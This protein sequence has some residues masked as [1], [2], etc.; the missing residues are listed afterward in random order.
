M[1]KIICIFTCLLLFIYCYL[2]IHLFTYLFIINLFICFPGTPQINIL[3][4]KVS[5]LKKRLEKMKL[6]SLKTPKELLTRSSDYLDP[7]LLRFFKWQILHSVEN[8]SERKYGIQEKSFA[9]ALYY[10]SPKAYT[11]LSSLFYLPPVQTLQSSLKTH[12]A[13]AGWSKHS[14]IVLKSRADSLPKEEILCGI[15]FGSM[16]IKEGLHFD[17]VTE[18]VK[19]SEGLGHNGTSLDQANRVLVFMVR[20]LVEKWKLVLGCF[21]HAGEVSTSNLKELYKESVRRVQST[22]HRVIFTVCDQKEKAHCS[23]FQALG[24][25]REDPSLEVEG[26][27]IHFFYD[28]PYLLRNL[29]NTLLSYDMNVKGA[30]VSWDHIKQ[31]IEVDERQKIRL[32]PRLTSTHVCGDDSSLIDET[33]ASQVMSRSVAAGIY[34]HCVM[35]MLPKDAVHTAEFIQQVDKL[36][37]LLHNSHTLQVC[38][39]T[40]GGNSKSSHQ[41]VISEATAYLASLEV[42][43]PP[44]AW[45]Q[46]VEGWLI[47][48]ASLQAVCQELNIYKI[49]CL[50]TSQLS[51]DCLENLFTKLRDQYEKCGCLTAHN[52]LKGLRSIII[53]DLVEIPELDDSK[54]ENIHFCDI[55]TNWESEFP[56]LS[57]DTDSLSEDSDESDEIFVMMSS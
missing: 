2:Y 4:N 11:F 23:L 32:E 9:L 35:G 34:T 41:T 15:V 28:S 39:V 27:K 54:G 48:L 6:L 40:G 44:D 12:F 19:G 13:V 30:I 3:Q 43:G 51:H 16:S 42:C 26:E 37:L 50:V 46:S 1:C 22:G 18:A 56:Y 29:T 53:N 24:L 55:S 49:K 25:T 36:F 7:R 38:E 47:N 10:E 52:F 8:D 33:V 14:M 45:C 20:G 21:F 31:F 5:R 17:S 57:S